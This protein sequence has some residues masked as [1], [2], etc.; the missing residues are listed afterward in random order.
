MAELRQKI[1]SAAHAGD[2]AAK[3]SLDALDLLRKD[4]KS[5]LARIIL[6]EGVIEASQRPG[7]G[8]EV[9]R[10]GDC[11]SPAKGVSAMAAVQ[12][13]Y[14][15]TANCDADFT[16]AGVSVTKVRLTGS[17]VTGS[18]VV[19]GTNNASAY[20]MYSY[21]PGT[22][23][24]FSNFSHYVSGGRG[25]FQTTVIVTRTIFGWNHSTRSGNLRL[26]TSGPGVVSC[27]CV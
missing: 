11:L 27:G 12:A 23:A 14:N 16:F 3:S 22:S 17:Y 18:G 4:K 13:T 24:S 26:V 20:V 25:Y 6:G 7:S 19:L 5:E 15:V 2:S 8:V 9:L 10:S 21:E 1:A